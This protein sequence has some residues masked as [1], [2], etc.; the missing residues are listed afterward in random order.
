[1]D[2]KIH[3]YD[4]ST[5]L[6]ENSK[7]LWY[8]WCLIQNSKTRAWS[9]FLEAPWFLCTVRADP[10]SLYWMSSWNGSDI[11]DRGYCHVCIPASLCW[12]ST[13][14]V[15][16]PSV[17]NTFPFNLDIPEGN[18][19]R[20]YQSSMSVLQITVPHGWRIACSCPSASSTCIITQGSVHQEYERLGVGWW[21]SAFWSLSDQRQK[22][23]AGS[24]S[25]ASG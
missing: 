19:S 17:Y 1:M 5:C 16:T 13:K 8:G 23:P 3:N 9:D 15:Q 12:F 7:Y 10:Q 22:R 24:N 14:G 6:E 18:S 11:I 4:A 20:L 2:L 25:C 21:K